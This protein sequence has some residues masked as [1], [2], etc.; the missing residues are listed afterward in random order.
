MNVLNGEPLSM[1]SSKQ[2]AQEPRRLVRAAVRLKIV[3]PV[4][5]GMEAESRW[6]LS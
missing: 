6:S 2:K 5:G 3:E 4:E 1:T